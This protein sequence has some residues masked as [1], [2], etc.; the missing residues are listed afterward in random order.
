[1]DAGP[2]G[3]VLEIP[4]DSNLLLMAKMANLI[5][6]SL[7]TGFLKGQDVIAPTL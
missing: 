6:L 7:Y 2:F 5:C 3:T 4:G 1:M